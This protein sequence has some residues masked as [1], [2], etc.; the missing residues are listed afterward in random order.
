MPFTRSD[1]GER[2]G[3]PPLTDAEKDAIVAE[4]NAA[5]AA[6]PLRDWKLQMRD[7]DADMPRWAEDIIDAMDA[8]A[9]ARIAAETMA[10]HAAKK[11]LRGKRPA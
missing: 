1:V 9:K 6:K 10:K 3:K 5:E 4:R 11:T 7:S 2:P 8:P